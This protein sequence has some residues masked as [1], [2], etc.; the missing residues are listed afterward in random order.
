MWGLCKELNGTQ[1]LNERDYFPRGEI[2]SLIRTIELRPENIS[3]TRHNAS[4][5]P[6]RGGWSSRQLMREPCRVA[7]CSG[8]E[9]SSP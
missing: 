6:D 5:H 4:L 3:V 7:L 1:S 8:F 2:I 9:S